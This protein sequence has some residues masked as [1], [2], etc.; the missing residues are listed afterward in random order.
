MKMDPFW[1]ELR[2]ELSKRS[3]TEHPLYLDLVKGTLGRPT[4]AE[5][6]AQLKYTVTDGIACL[7]LIV[8][9]APRELKKELAENL[10]GELT[11]TP[12]VPSHW[13]LALRA[14][15]AAGF[16]EAD[17]DRRPM[18]PETKIYP[19]TVSAYAMRGAWLEA[20]SFVALGIEDMFTRFCDGAAKAVQEHYGYTEPQ[21]LYFSAHVGADEAH[22]ELG[23]EMAAEHARTDEKRQ[24]VRR[25]AHEGRTMW[26]NMHSAVY[27]AG[28]KKRAPWLRVEL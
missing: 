16:S 25:A 10:F 23:W 24:S 2:A 1:A 8:P 4:L 22:S 15:M 11:G 6:C 14:G 28:E 17:I 19:D 20:L 12:E 21:A 7:A 27:E 26:W 5:L 9:Q 18:L 13:E 3:V